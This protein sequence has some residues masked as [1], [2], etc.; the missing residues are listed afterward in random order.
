MSKKFRCMSLFKF[1]KN[2]FTRLFLCR[3]LFRQIDLYFCNVI[4]ER[5]LQ[6]AAHTAFKIYMTDVH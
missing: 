2:T 6:T 4:T 1:D 5:K 3:S